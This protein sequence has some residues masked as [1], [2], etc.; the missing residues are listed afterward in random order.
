M[1]KTFVRALLINAVL[2][3]IV[4]R[5][6]AGRVEEEGRAEALWLLYPFVVLGNAL[7][8]TLMLTAASRLFRFL[9]RT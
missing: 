6:R 5:T 4:T 2:Q 7:V 9:R 8:W 1:T 3:F